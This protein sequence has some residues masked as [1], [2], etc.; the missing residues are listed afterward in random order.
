MFMWPRGVGTKSIYKTDPCGSSVYNTNPC[1]ATG[2]EQVKIPWHQEASLPRPRSLLQ[3]QMP[4]RGAVDSKMG[5]CTSL[6]MR[7]QNNV[8]LTVKVGR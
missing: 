5:L 8:A 3:R 2:L 7:K 4:M 6:L 1:N